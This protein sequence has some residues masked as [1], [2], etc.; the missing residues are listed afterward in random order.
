MRRTRIPSGVWVLLLALVTAVGGV[1]CTESDG[2]AEPRTGSQIYRAVCATCHGRSGEG[3]VGP[4]LS[5][6]ALRYPN[7]AD[8]I[9]LVASGRGGMP[10]FG[11]Q[12]RPEQIDAVV[13][14]TRTRFVSNESTSTTVF[15]GPTL[16]PSTAP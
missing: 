5:D 14:Y 8:Q 13:Q 12:L 10:G 7:V 6:I 3:F 16:P 2:A 11:G 9:A 15:V 1:A 4:S